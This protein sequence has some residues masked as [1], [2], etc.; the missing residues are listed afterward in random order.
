LRR[1]IL[2]QFFINRAECIN[3]NCSDIDYKMRYYMSFKGTRRLA[4]GFKNSIYNPN[5]FIIRENILLGL[6][7][8]ILEK[9][10]SRFLNTE[11]RE[12]FISF[13]SDREFF[14]QNRLQS[15]LIDI[16]KNGNI[17]AVPKSILFFSGIFSILYFIRTGVTNFLINYKDMCED[18]NIKERK[19]V[20]RY[21][22][23]YVKYIVII[24]RG[25]ASFIEFDWE[26]LKKEI[27]K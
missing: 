22:R 27:I 4:G 12:T 16:D 24:M 3:C 18:Y 9:F 26:E 8:E 21:S 15:S 2:S 6:L 17:I 23:Y 10:R 5:R 25:L 1:G 14:S 11:S 13:D 7:T 20:R 19:R